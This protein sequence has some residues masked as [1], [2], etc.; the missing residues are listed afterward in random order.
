[1]ILDKTVNITSVGSNIKRLNSLGY[2]VKYG[3]HIEI[4]VEHLSL[5]SHMRINCKCDICGKEKIM[6]YQSY[7]NKT[8]YD[9]KYYCSKCSNVKRT[10]VINE[11][12]GVNN[13]FQLQETKEKMKKS[14]MEKY[15]VDHPNKSKDVM[16]KMKNTNVER[17]GCENVFQNESIKDRIKK[18]NINNLGVEYPSQN[19]DVKNKSCQTNLKKLGVMYP[20]QNNVVFH[21]SKKSSFKI[22]ELFNLSYQGSY[23]LDFL[24]FCKEKN[25][26]KQIS[27]GESIKYTQNDKTC[28]YHPDFY[29]EKLKLI[30]EIKSKYWYSVHLEKNLIKERF[31]KNMGFDYIVIMD[32][33][34][35]E[36]MNHID[37][38]NFIIE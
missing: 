26:I 3:D 2:N 30:I 32:K 21:K 34:Y 11:K 12:Y 23:E 18:T 4:P 33:D 17:Y 24:N 7:I 31:V 22:N 27:K 36:F 14:F 35:S 29:I 6:T 5:N 13:V 1:M 19:K 37:K 16:D 8:K 25:I 38:L 28:Y 9:N 10:K 20:Q 15:G